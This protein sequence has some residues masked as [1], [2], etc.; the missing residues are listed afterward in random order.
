MYGPVDECA[1]VWRWS[2]LAVSICVCMVCAL[3][4]SV[5]LG[6]LGVSL[7]LVL[8]M[9]CADTHT[10]THLPRVSRT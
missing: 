6:E 1:C 7:G 3:G 5:G 4:F 9:V 8:C 2:C 10:L